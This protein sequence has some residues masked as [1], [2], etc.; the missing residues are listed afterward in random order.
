MAGFTFGLL[1]TFVVGIGLGFFY[2]GGLWLTVRRL[3]DARQPSLWILLSFLGRASLS[4]LGL[5]LASEG[6]WERI[7]IGLL[8]FVIARVVLVRRL[9]PDSSAFP[10]Q[11]GSHP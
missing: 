7:L 9:L 5:Y 11:R 3:P 2:Y 1:F 10:K 8:G 4:L 6:R